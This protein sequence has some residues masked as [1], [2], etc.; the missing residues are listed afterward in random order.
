MSMMGKAF[1]PSEC[2]AAIIHESIPE[3]NFRQQMQLTAGRYVDQSQD[4][5]SFGFLPTIICSAISG[6][7]GKAIPVTAGWQ[8]IQIAAKLFDDIE[9]GEAT[10]RI[11]NATN[12]ATGFLF[13]AHHALDRLIDYGVSHEQSNQVKVGLNHAC[14]R[15]CAGQ[16]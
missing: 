15:A 11:A 4:G 2:I 7:T 5:L 9:D 1:T 6:E 3:G 13:A 16:D 12:L 10:D 8:L 14:L